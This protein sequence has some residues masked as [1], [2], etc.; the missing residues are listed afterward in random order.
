MEAVR[1]NPFFVST[2]DIPL[3]FDVTMQHMLCGKCEASISEV[4]ESACS[5]TEHNSIQVK[6]VQF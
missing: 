6:K 4:I 1:V 2:S 5:Y 3:N